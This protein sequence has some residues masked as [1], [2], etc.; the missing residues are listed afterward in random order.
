M[1]SKLTS[2][3]LLDPKLTY[4]NHGSFGACPKSVIENLGKWQMRMEKDPVQLLDADISPLLA[5]S[6]NALGNFVGCEGDDLVYYPN[7]T[8]AVN[9]VARSLKLKLDDEVLSTNHIYGALDF[10][11]KQVCKDTKAKFIKAELPPPIKSKDEFLNK[12]FSYVSA[13]TRVIFISHITS[14]TAMIFPVEEIIQFARERDILAIIDGA[15]VP[16]HLPLNITALDPDIYT[17]ACHKWMC[18]PKGTSFLYVKKSLQND[19]MPP[20][21]SWGWEMELADKSPFLNKHEWQGTRDMTP[22]LVVPEAIKFLNDNN[23]QERGKLNRALVVSKRNQ[24]LELL[25]SRPICPNDWLG[26]M[27]TIELPIDDPLQ[28]KQSLLEKYNIQI[29]VFTWENITVLRYSMHFYNKEEDLNRLIGA[30][31]ELLD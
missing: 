22:F 17:G 19:I 14:M 11:W 26:Q 31:K 15:H 7:P 28:F 2:Q 3:F 10:T 12:F 21:I 30:V 13:R 27:A 18:A 4:L 25:N 8:H 20:V 16:G 9:A 5:N 23:W 24:F 6:R 1:T 29:P